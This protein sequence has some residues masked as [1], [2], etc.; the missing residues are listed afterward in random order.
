MSLENARDSY[1][2]LLM[3]KAEHQEQLRRDDKIFINSSNKQ[4]RTQTSFRQV[5]DLYYEPCDV[6]KDEEEKCPIWE[7]TNDDPWRDGAHDVVSSIAQ[8]ER[9]FSVQEVYDEMKTGD[10]G[11]SITLSS[12][13][14]RNKGSNTKRRNCDQSIFDCFNPWKEMISTA[15]TSSNEDSRGE[16]KLSPKDIVRRSSVA[17]QLYLSQTAT[18][19]RFCT[20]SLFNVCVECEGEETIQTQP[21]ALIRRSCLRHADKAASLNKSKK[22]KVHFS[23]LKRVLRVRKFNPIESIEIWF[24]REDFDYFKNEMTLLIQEDGASRELAQVWLEA[25][26][27]GDEEEGDVLSSFSRPHKRDDSNSSATS[28]WWHDYDHS[29]RGLERYASPGQA[30]QIVASYKVAVRKVMGEQSRQRLLGCICIPNA[31]NADKIAE[32]Y[33]EYTSW[34]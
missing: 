28:K 14:L 16:E 29:R 30:K 32:I 11:K 3:I 12:M 18:R 5:S 6:E 1:V 19:R 24:Q 4:L 15:T 26:G 22:Y 8:C 2:D 7:M 31:Y 21:R 9:I 13:V 20:P 33:H 23:E 34:R 17:V 10:A 25:Q 27:E